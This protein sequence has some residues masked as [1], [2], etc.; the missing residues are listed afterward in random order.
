MVNSIYRWFLFTLKVENNNPLSFLN[1]LVSKHVST[2]VFRKAYSVSLSDY[3]SQQNMA[4]FSTYVY[5]AILTFSDPSNLSIELNYLKPVVFFRGYNRSVINKALGKFKKNKR[6]ACHSDSCPDS[7]ASDFYSS[8]SFKISE[9]LS[10]FGFEF[11]FKPVSKIKFYSP[12]SPI[13]TQNRSWSIIFNVL[14]LFFFYTCQTRRW[15]KVR[16][17]EHRRKVKMRR[18]TAH[19]LFLI[20]DMTSLIFTLQRLV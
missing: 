10:C 19:P 3:P 1:V 20:V 13:L 17:D 16:L 8:I 15:V 7:V 5:H 18:F 4:V 11:S 12:K 14:L 9:M 2:I 6:S